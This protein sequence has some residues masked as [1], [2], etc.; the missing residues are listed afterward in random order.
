MKKWRL[1]ALSIPVIAA[2]MLLGERMTVQP[3]AA[4]EKA[5][6][7]SIVDVPTPTSPHEVSS[8]LCGQ[9]HST[10][11]EEWKGSMH[12]QSTA[13]ND[14]I[15]GFMYRKVMGDPQQEGLTNKKGKYPVCLQC[16]A[17]NAA[18]QKKT[19]LDAKP[20]FN[21]G[22]NCIAC[23]TITGFKGIEGEDGK[24]RL[25]VAAYDISQTSLQAPS[26]KEYSTSPE[27]DGANSK[28]FHPYPMTGKHGTLFKTS[29]MCMG[30]HSKRN[31]EHGI[32]VCATGDEIKASNSSVSCQSCHMP[33]VDGRASHAMLGGHD[34]TMVK[35]GVAL[36]LAV[37]ESGDKLQ[38]KVTM[39]NLL[40][41][42]YPTGAPFRN[43]YL[44]LTAHNDKGEEIWKNFETHPLKDDKQGILVY[45][46][47]DGEGNPTGAPTA[48]EVL[49]DSRLKP[50][51]EREL[52]YE[53]PAEGVVNVRAELLYNLMLPEMI[54]HLE[55][56]VGDDLKKP[57]QAAFAEVS[58]VKAD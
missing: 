32:P 29:D 42:N 51:E 18:I 24:L 46:L 4:E 50:H 6:T 54:K 23:H 2:F 13:L 12:A 28:P 26:G 17:P 3:V 14:P 41:H 25:G 49:S 9:C 21:E 7:S 8:E 52:E 40:P 36:Q 39:T 56:I 58:L 37:E 30:C 34:K 55:V 15:H 48:K 53:I 20:A 10:I 31:N 16:H 5:E 45:V 47:G 11:Y 19:K 27:A 57:K 43:V 44:Q 22:V 1:L 38:A 33:I 35:R